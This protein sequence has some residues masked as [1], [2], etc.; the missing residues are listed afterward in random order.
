MQCMKCGRETEGSNVFCRRCLEQMAAR[1]VK[2]GTPVTIHQRPAKK[3]AQ[4]V[5]PQISPQERL[6]RLQRRSRRLTIAVSVLAVLLALSA[7]GLGWKLYQDL[8]HFPLG[9][10]YTTVTSTEASAAQT[11]PTAQTGG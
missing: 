1:P 10:N 3:P 11:D 4:P 8:I 2:P 7:S 9:Q 6:T 5:K